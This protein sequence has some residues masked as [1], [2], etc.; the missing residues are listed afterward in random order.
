MEMALESELAGSVVADMSRLLAT[1]TCE[2]TGVL[3]TLTAHAIGAG[4]R[5][6]PRTS[7]PNTRCANNRSGLTSS[8]SAATP[9]ADTLDPAPPATSGPG[10]GP[11]PVEPDDGPAAVGA[12]D[13][14]PAPAALAAPAPGAL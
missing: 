14:L 7:P 12:V 13:A 1:N 11:P 9:G 3:T 2:P 5:S 6:H 10:A 8:P 4:Q